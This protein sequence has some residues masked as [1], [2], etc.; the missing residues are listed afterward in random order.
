[1]KT[2]ALLRFSL[3]SL[4][5]AASLPAQSVAQMLPAARETAGNGV[6]VKNAIV[7]VVRSQRGTSLADLIEEAEDIRPEH[8]AIISEILR[9]VPVAC[10]NRIKNFYVR[11]DDPKERGL[12]G[13]DTLIISGNLPPEEFR[14]V[15]VHE[16]LGH[17]TDLGCLT[18]TPESGA[19]AYKDGNE[20]IYENDPSVLFYRLSWAS[21]TERKSGLR[22]RDFV[23]GYAHDADAFEDLAESVTFYFFH[24]EEFRRMA[25]TNRILA[26]KFHWI[27]TYVFPAG[28]TPSLSAYQWDRNAIPW[29]ATKL[30]Y[31]WVA[32]EK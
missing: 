20:R 9:F 4:L 27:E 8:R 2:S 6:S 11:Y 30:A 7:A 12:A 14:A 28:N 26:A 32:S 17:V 13:K 1:M 21:A 22:T 15:L 31:V 23:S 16:L 5:V 29:D 3:A 19:S 24:R 10:R 25:K 18:G